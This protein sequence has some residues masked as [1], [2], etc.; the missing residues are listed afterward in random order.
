MLQPSPRHKTR[1]GRRQAGQTRCR[2][3]PGLA[4]LLFAVAFVRTGPFLLAAIL[5]IAPA[6]L[7]PVRPIGLGEGERAVS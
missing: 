6:V 2:Q 5:P 1:A 3:L 7:T 4:S